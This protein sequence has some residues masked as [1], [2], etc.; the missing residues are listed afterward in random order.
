[1]YLSR[2]TVG[3]L[4]HAVATAAAGFESS[5]K[6]GLVYVETTHPYD[7]QIFVG[8]EGWSDLTW[9]YNYA[10]TPSSSYDNLTQTEFEFVP[11][12]FTAP[13]AGD[14]SFVTTI[15]NL[16]SEGR[17][18]THVLTYNEPDGT[19]AT[20]GSNVDPATAAQGW[21]SQIIP[22]QK[23]GIKAGAPAVTGAQTGFTWLQQFFAACTAAGTN[24]TADFIPIHWY[25]DFQG[26]ASHVGQVS[27]T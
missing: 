10:A 18:I 5:S 13:S 8:A 19:Y 22:L 11:M 6:R 12:L 7:L 21:I 1:M 25:G 9:Y 20:G 17:N 23:L 4:L 2:S 24:C 15:K 27:V 14:N 26:M 3:L 16:I